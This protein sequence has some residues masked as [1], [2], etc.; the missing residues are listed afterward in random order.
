MTRLTLLLLL[1]SPIFIHAQKRLNLNHYNAFA[2][3][4]YNEKAFCVLDDS[5]FLWKYN[6]QAVKWEKTPIQLS[7]EMPF[8]QFLSDFIPMSEKGTPV[9][10]VYAGCGIV[11]SM[12]NNMIKRHDHSF[13]HMNQFGGSFFMDEGEPRIYGG[14]GLFTSKNIITRYDTI[15]REWF[16]LNTI[17]NPPP[18]GVKNIIKKHGKIYYVLDGLRGLYSQYQSFN[19]LWRFNVQTKKW[20]NL[21]RVN[22]TIL[23]K[24]IELNYE[25]SQIQDNLFSCF[26]NKIVVYDFEKLRYRKYKTNTYDLYRKIIN[27]GEL[28]LIFKSKS[29]PSRYVEITNSDFLKNLD[30]EEG[31][32]LLKES[33]FM[34]K[35]KWLIG[36]FLFL[37]GILIVTLV[38]K[39]SKRKKQLVSNI[40]QANDALFDEFNSTEK[41]L[42]QLLIQFHET[43]LEIS[44]IND[45]VNHDQPSIDT[46]KKRRETLLKEL[47]YKLAAKFNIPHEEIFV[48]ER[49]KA[50]KRMK[51][52]FLNKTVLA[53]FLTSK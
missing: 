41:E 9:Y 36:F 23:G 29:Q 40:E 2:F 51:L 44:H 39:Y 37:L 12:E 26:P 10:F 43:G 24:Q 21:G 16:V 8:E 42:I 49:M 13:Y 20:T 46:L 50:D 4:D 17:N 14:Y 19:N 1:L 30:L 48:E 27:V 33:S 6:Q 35:F 38:T 25:N 3:Y 18:P 52:L 5:T 47:R 32:I 34:D 15:E 28:F 45:L 53:D 11:Y 31:D 22:P 7:I